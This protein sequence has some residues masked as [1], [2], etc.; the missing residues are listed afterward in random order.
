MGMIDCC[1]TPRGNHWMHNQDDNKLNAIIDQYSS[2]GGVGANE[3]KTLS[4]WGS[5]YI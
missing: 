2:E 4:H 1:L 5:N 3:T